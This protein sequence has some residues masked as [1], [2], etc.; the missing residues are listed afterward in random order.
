MFV[1]YLN[2]VDINIDF[3]MIYN[4]IVSSQY[5]LFNSFLATTRGP[6]GLSSF[7]REYGDKRFTL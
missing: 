3:V 2:F 5:E 4:L 1:G 6:K 7:T